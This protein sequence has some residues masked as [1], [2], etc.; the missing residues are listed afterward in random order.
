MH[1]SSNKCHI[2]LLPYTLDKVTLRLCKMY[3]SLCSNPVPPPPAAYFLRMH[4]W[5]HSICTSH[6]ARV[7]KLN[8]T[9]YVYLQQVSLDLRLMPVHA[10]RR[11]VYSLANFSMHKFQ[12]STVCNISHLF[13]QGCTSG[14]VDCTKVHA[15]ALNRFAIASRNHRLS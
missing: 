13:S 3:F 8:E 14:K 7:Y 15:F 1:G 9:R 5:T 4:R 10:I 12:V 2:M 11:N 6:A